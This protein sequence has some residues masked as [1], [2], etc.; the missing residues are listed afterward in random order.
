MSLDSISDALEKANI[1]PADFNN[2][3]TDWNGKGV[4]VLHTDQGDWLV[5]KIPVESQGIQYP[6]VERIT[7]V[8]SKRLP[9]VEQGVEQVLSRHH[10]KFAPIA[11]GQRDVVVL[12]TSDYTWILMPLLKVEADS[13]EGKITEV[14]AVDTEKVRVALENKGIFLSPLPETDPYFVM[15]RWV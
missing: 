10:L 1:P 6:L 4:Q 12:E 8:N 5:R 11:L 15:T 14:D 3:T 7:S 9:H 13:L 2:L